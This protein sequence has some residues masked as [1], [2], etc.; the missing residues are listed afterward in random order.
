MTFSIPN[1]YFFFLQVEQK[2]NESFVMISALASKRKS[3]QKNKALYY[4]KQLLHN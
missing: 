1:L 3:N 4:I 2:S